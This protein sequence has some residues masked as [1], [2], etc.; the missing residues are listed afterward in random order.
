MFI[1]IFLGHESV[2]NY[3]WRF[4]LSLLPLAKDKTPRKV[5]GNFIFFHH[6]D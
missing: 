3:C 4:K 5:P 6:I 1:L 2:A